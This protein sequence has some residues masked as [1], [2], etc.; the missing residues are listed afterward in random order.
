MNRPTWATVLPPIETPVRVM[1]SSTLGDE[2]IEMRD[3][4]GVLVMQGLSIR[5]WF[6]FERIAATLNAPSQAQQD[7][8]AEALLEYIAGH[9]L[10][11]AQRQAV[12]AARDH[13]LS[14]YY[15]RLLQAHI[16]V[17][18]IEA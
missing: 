14:S 16:E 4:S 15:E 3:A 8:D 9:K 10:T 18:E 17:K 11:R 6:A 2:Y 1:P 13:M 12:L 5:E 7:R